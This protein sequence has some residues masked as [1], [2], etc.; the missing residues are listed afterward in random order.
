MTYEQRTTKIC[1]S[2]G[3]HESEETFIRFPVLFASGPFEEPESKTYHS[4]RD[5]YPIDLIYRTREAHIHDGQ[6]LHIDF[7]RDNVPRESGN[8][9][10]RF[11]Q[12]E[13]L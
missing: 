4:C 10:C 11:I 3:K 5:C 9:I 12:E 7:H 1:D 13:L 8:E 6:I 2:C